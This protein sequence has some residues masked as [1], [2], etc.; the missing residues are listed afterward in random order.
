MTMMTQQPLSNWRKV[1]KGKTNKRQQTNQNHK[2]NKSTQLPQTLL[3]PHA[4]TNPPALPTEA[5]S[6]G[7]LEG[8]LPTQSQSLDRHSKS[9]W[10]PYTLATGNGNKVRAHLRWAPEC[11]APLC[12]QSV[13]DCKVTSQIFFFIF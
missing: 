2:T 13:S 3:L 6:A 4:I 10:K 5:S 12:S 7:D 8:P 11:E 9:G 1:Q